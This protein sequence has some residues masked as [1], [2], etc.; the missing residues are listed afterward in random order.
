ML[1]LGGGSPLGCASTRPQ[2]QVLLLHQIA[3]LSP[4]TAE[5][6]LLKM[7][8]SCS[9]CSVHLCSESCP[10][11][12]ALCLKWKLPHLIQMFPISSFLKLLLSGLAK[13]AMHTNTAQV[14]EASPER[15]GPGEL[16]LYLPAVAPP[17]SPCFGKTSFTF[18]RPNDFI[19]YLWQT[20]Q[21]ACPSYM[22]TARNPSITP[23]CL[24]SCS[25]F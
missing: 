14:G 3:Q 7:S 15:A 17:L 1:S 13:G 9:H 21:P 11:L 10:E 2:P 24:L 25:I 18:Y 8:I 23:H 19:I 22:E 20:Q 4:P 16:F 6:V 5:H 12:A